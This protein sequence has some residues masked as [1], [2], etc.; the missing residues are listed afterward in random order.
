MK[1]VL[2]LHLHTD[3]EIESGSEDVDSHQS[4]CVPALDPKAETSCTHGEDQEPCYGLSSTGA[5]T[6]AVLLG[7]SSKVVCVMS[8]PPQSPGVRPE[9]HGVRVV[10]EGQLKL[11]D[12]NRGSDHNSGHWVPA[13]SQTVKPGDITQSG[14]KVASL[15]HVATYIPLGFLRSPTTPGRTQFSRK[16]SEHQEERTTAYHDDRQFETEQTVV[17]CITA[18]IPVTV[19][20]VQDHRIVIPKHSVNA[21]S[22]LISPDFVKEEENPTSTT[23]LQT[24]D[25]AQSTMPTSSVFRKS[26]NPKAPENFR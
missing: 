16:S 8:P 12:K 5:G 1:R 2:R 25:I 9:G 22:Y 3:F 11:G 17:P 21:E 19:R 26:T 10:P 14:G 20:N 23:K 4:P 24:V 15:P 6:T 7:E 13:C 18:T